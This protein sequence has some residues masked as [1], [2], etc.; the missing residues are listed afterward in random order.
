MKIT[1]LGFT[2]E[3]SIMLVPAGAMK[4]FDKGYQGSA[5]LLSEMVNGDHL[6]EAYFTDRN[7][8]PEQASQDQ[9]I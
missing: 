7:P 4:D 3:G 5:K 9:Q 1:V 2:Q 8:K 6:F